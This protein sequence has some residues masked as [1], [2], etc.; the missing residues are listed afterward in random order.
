MVAAAVI[1]GSFLLLLY[2]FYR[3]ALPKPLPGIPY[4]QHAASRVLGDIPEMMSYVK[5]TK[6]IF[7]SPAAASTGE[8]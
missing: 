1:A 4:N 6:R 5:R 7:V 3:R 2:L 8:I